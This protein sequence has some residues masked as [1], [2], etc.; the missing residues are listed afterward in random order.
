MQS[1]TQGRRKAGDSGE[2]ILWPFPQLDEARIAFRKGQLAL[3]AGAP[4]SGKSA[5]VLYALIIGYYRKATSRVLYFSA[6]TDAAI[7][8]KR[9]AQMLTGYTAG[10]IEEQLSEGGAEII[11]GIVKAGTAH[12]TLDYNSYPTADDI[13]DQVYAYYEVYG[14]FPD[15]IVMD[16]LKNLRMGGS[17]GEFEELEEN[18]EFLQL[19]ARDTGAAVIAL[20]HVTGDYESGDKPIPLSGVRGK[21][22]KTPETVLTVFRGQGNLY[23]SPVKNRDGEADASGK[24]YIAITADM[25]TMSYS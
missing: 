12:I 13:R 19:I 15:V 24:R 17:D 5:W 21:V 6:D 1:L 3:V 25:A 9:A 7:M 10:Y 4:G 11:E 22:T 20:H 8:F 2:P 18:C 23:I 14:C 16:N